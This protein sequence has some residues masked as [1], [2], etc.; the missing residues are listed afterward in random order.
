[1]T[2]KLIRM[3]LAL[4]VGLSCSATVVASEIG[5]QIVDQVDLEHYR[6]YLDDELYT[7]DGDSRGRFGT[8][9]D[10]CRDAIV[11]IF[12]SFAL[13]VEL[14]P[15]TYGGATYY[16]V[17]ATQPGTVDPD[18]QYIVGG[19][20]DSVNNPG[21]DDNASGVAGTLEAARIL[22]LYETEYTLKYI[23]FDLEEVGLVG[24][25]AYANEHQGDDIRGVLVLDMIAHDA[26]AYKCRIYGDP[27]SNPIKYLVADA[28]TEYAPALDYMI[29]GE[30]GEPPDFSDHVP[31]EDVG[32]QACLLIEDAHGSNP[33]YHRQCD[34]VDTPDYIHYP[35]ALEFARV[36]AGFLAD[37]ALAHPPYDCDDDGIPDADEIQQDPSLDCNGNSV[38]DVCEH[39]PFDDCNANGIADACDISDGTSH[40]FDR[41][42][43]PDECDCL[44][45]LDGDEAIGQADLGILLASWA[46]DA[47]GDLDG[48]NDT[49]QGDLGILLGNWGEDCY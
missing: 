8:E 27:E 14:H 31:F 1:M 17:V 46:V 49:D 3:S 48:D 19:H 28:I 45:D 2:A 21:A 44:G 18:A 38:L 6:T 20:Y 11:A 22:S 35:Y 4:A 9:H 39:E 24:S 40:D 7:H 15:F 47:G 5:H 26:G 30:Y 37:H 42:G 10:L 23:A 41:N 16:N 29:V 13:D 12:E 36:A 33:C 32:F 34:S 43:I 25:R